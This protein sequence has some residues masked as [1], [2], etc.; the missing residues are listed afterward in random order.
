M[1]TR[2]L[3]DSGLRLPVVGLG[4]NN[5]GG[6]TDPVRSRA[7][8]DAAIDHGVVFFDTADI[9]AKG[10]SE[11]IIGA[12]IKGRRDSVI[13]ATKFGHEMGYDI[14]APRGGHA[15]IRHAVTESLRRLDTDHIDLY[16]LHRPDGVTPIAETVEALAELQAEG[17]IGHYG[18]SNVT[19]QQL[20]EAHAA[21]QSRNLPPPVSV[22]NEY[23]LLQREAEAEV[24]PRCEALQVGF[25]PYFPLA[26]GLLT[27][28]YRRGEPAPAGSR[29]ANGGHA[30]D[31]ATADFDLIEG[32]ERFARDH[33]HT[34][35]D[36]AFAGLLAH[37]PVTSVIAGAT[38]PEQ[39][40]ANAAAG[41]WELT[42]TELR[43]LDD[44][45]PAAV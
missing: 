6:R 37:P 28:K 27:G 23:S 34:I 29:L 20:T 12:A 5:F 11:R 22:Q 38:R 17:T 45:L 44:L 43:E 15:Y 18:L 39:I 35:L 31:P 9:Y 14:A 24:L 25:L 33:G 2:E 8:I 16:Q 26:S 7:V 41:E 32:L 3:G 21:A 30:Y 10:E 40:E 36:L 4:C 19:A 1:R 13:L 42:E